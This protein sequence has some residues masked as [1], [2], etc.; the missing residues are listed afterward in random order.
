MYMGMRVKPT[1]VLIMPSGGG[2]KTAMAAR[3]YAIMKNVRSRLIR[4]PLML[5][6]RVA[7]PG[8]GQNG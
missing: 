2:T 5:R 3:V 8:E 1:I 6:W 4:T 7:A